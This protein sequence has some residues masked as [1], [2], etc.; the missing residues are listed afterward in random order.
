VPEKHHR[1]AVP[2][3]YTTLESLYATVL[4]LKEAVEVLQNQR[5]NSEDAAVVFRDLVALGVMN[6]HQIPKDGQPPRT[7]GVHTK[8]S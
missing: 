2:E 6:K 8:P 7:L 5:G 4:A 3:P 1:T